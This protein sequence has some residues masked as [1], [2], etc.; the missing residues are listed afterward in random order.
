M[1]TNVQA[2]WLKVSW[3][4]TLLALVGGL[5][6]TPWVLAN[7]RGANSDDPATP[8]RSD[9]ES[10]S[11]SGHEASEKAM[12]VFYLEVV[13]KDV[14]GV[15]AAYEA[16]SGVKFSEPVAGLGGARTASMPN[17][18][19]VGVRPQLRETEDPVVRPYWLVD[20]I[21]AALERAAKAGGEVAHP[22]LEIPG[23]GTF[24]IY[25]QGGN[26]HGLWEK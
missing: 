18:G 24:A 2:R 23:I 9:T 10:E 26:D 5:M 1:K 21:K 8:R 25:L 20:D 3:V 16:A 22:P 15:V 13:T 12:Q 17:G 19:M 7:D 4:V 6:A 11:E 14:D